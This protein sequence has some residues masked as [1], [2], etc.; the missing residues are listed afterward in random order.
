MTGTDD[1][2]QAVLDGGILPHLHNLM[3]NSRPTI[4]R[5]S[6]VR[7]SGDVILLGDSKTVVLQMA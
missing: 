6:H 4:V 1:Q 7:A 2:T 3:G 5:V